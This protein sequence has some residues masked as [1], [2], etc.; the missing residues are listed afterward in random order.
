M[1]VQQLLRQLVI[2][3]DPRTH[4][5]S[6]PF[7]NTWLPLEEDRDI[8]TGE[9]LAV[10]LDKNGLPFQNLCWGHDS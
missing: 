5:M 1:T 8:T 2:G 3:K 6:V 9:A 10:P 7:V 4:Q